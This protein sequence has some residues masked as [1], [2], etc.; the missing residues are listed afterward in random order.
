MNYLIAQRQLKTNL[1]LPI[2]IL[3]GILS[4]TANKLKKQLTNFKSYHKLIHLLQIS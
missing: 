3:K 2:K 4:S 1:N